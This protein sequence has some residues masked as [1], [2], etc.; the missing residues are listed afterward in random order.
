MSPVSGFNSETGIAA[1]VQCLGELGHHCTCRRRF[2]RSA[3]SHEVVLHIDHDHGG[4]LRVNHVNLHAL[5]PCIRN[6]DDL[7]P[8]TSVASARAHLFSTR[9]LVSFSA[10]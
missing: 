3:H 5:P 2:H 10:C 4:L 1:D 7:L 6:S 9:S 8:M